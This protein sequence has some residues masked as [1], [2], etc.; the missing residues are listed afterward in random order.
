LHQTSAP[1]VGCG[2]ADGAEDGLAGWWREAAAR[3]LEGRLDREAIR[4]FEPLGRI[5]EDDGFVTS[6]AVASGETDAPH[7]AVQLDVDFEISHCRLA[8]FA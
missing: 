3:Q 7:A 8:R 6:N 1:S 4:I 2:V 5:L